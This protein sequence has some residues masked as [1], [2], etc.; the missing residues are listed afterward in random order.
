MYVITLYTI[1][2]SNK[3]Y[4]YNV[5]WFSK[6]VF[7]FFGFGFKLVSVITGLVFKYG[8]FLHVNLSE[9]RP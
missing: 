7:I 6:S 3:L 2:K 8:N 1:W 9:S 5:L 4:V